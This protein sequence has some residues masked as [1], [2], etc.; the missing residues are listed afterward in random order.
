MYDRSLSCLDIDTS[1]QSDGVRTVYLPLLTLP[2]VK[3]ISIPYIITYHKGTITHRQYRDTG[4]I[5]YKTHN[6]DKYPFFIA[7]TY[8]QYRNTGNIVYKKQNKDK[9]PFCITITYRQYRETGNIVYKTQNKDKYP[10]CI[11]I[12]DD[13]NEELIL[14]FVLF[15]VHNFACVSVLYISDCS[16]EWMLVA[17]LSMVLSSGSRSRDL[18]PY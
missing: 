17:V 9:Y 2:L 5:V 14:V 16:E 3:L 1:I 4:N 18:K 10:F 15:L 12:T 7:I 8:R 6:K 13:C 11:T